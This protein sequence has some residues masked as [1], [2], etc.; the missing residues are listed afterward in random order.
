MIGFCLFY[1]FH[2]QTRTEIRCLREPLFSIRCFF[3]PHVFALHWKLKTLHARKPLDS[4][5]WTY[6]NRTTIHLYHQYR[7]TIYF[8]ELEIFQ[9]MKNTVWSSKFQINNFLYFL[10]SLTKSQT[11]IEKLIRHDESL[12]LIWLALQRLSSCHLL[13][14]EAFRIS[15]PRSSV[16]H[17]KIVPNNSFRWSLFMFFLVSRV[18]KWFPFFWLCYWTLIHCTNEHIWPLPPFEKI[19]SQVVRLQYW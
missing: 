12:A 14:L 17:Q 15:F 2:I 4:Y 18:F 10:S 6:S 7:S 11:V 3:D 5:I 19:S 9:L 8:W 16:Q 1:F 13:S